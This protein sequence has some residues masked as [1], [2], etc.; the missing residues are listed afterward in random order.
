MIALLVQC[1]KFTRSCPSSSDPPDEAQRVMRLIFEP[2]RLRLYISP[3]GSITKA[4][5]GAVR[6]LV[7]MDSPAPTVPYLPEA[8]R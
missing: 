5:M 1:P 4:I 7:S 8:S 6:V 3:C 2:S